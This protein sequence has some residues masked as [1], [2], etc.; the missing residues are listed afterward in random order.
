MKKGK[1][2]VSPST[3]RKEYFRRRLKRLLAKQDH[4]CFY[5]NHSLTKEKGKHN[6]MTLDHVV[7]R[8]HLRENNITLENNLVVACFKCN[9]EKGCLPLTAFLQL[10]NFKLGGQHGW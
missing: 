9:Q 4:R 10:K 8:T 6:S 7:P 5:C 3:K 2:K 1:K